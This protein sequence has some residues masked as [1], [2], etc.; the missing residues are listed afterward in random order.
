MEDERANAKLENT[1]RR[2]ENTYKDL[3]PPI[4]P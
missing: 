2:G 3:V 4:V 1:K